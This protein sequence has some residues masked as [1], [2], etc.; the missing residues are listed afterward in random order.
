MHVLVTGGAGFIG[1]HTVEALL[2]AGMRVR[3]FDNFSSGT[4]DNLP[5]HPHLHICQGDI[6]NSDEVWQALEGMSHVLHLAA[7]VSVQASVDDPITSGSVNISGFVN[8]LDCARRAGVERLVYASSAAVYGVPEALPLNEESRVQALAPYGLEKL[9][10]DQYA[11]LYR[12]LFDFPSLGLRYFNVYG[13]RQDPRSPYAGVISK[14]I[15]HINQ[16]SPLR[17]FGD[18]WQTRDFIFVKDVARANC[19]ALQSDAVG[20]CNIGTGASLSLRDLAKALSDCIGSP[21]DVDYL[22]PREGD[23]RDSATCIARMHQ[24]FG[25]HPM[26]DIRQGLSELVQEAQETHVEAA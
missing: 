3:V 14:F 6:R 10:N 5:S 21:L 25:S 23:I 18:G 13:P 11:E 4:S 12:L 2:G 9:V 16:G 24:L 22:P 20:I 15:D 1:S 17:I 7:Q 19:A 8:V 26:T